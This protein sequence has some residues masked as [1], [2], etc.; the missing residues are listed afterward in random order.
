MELIKLMKKRNEKIENTQEELF[1]LMNDLDGAEVE[2]QGKEA[3]IMHIDWNEK[4]VLLNYDDINMEW[5]SF[6]D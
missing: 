3:I 5:V 2:Y 6:E 1:E 4:Q